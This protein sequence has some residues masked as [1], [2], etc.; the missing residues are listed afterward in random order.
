MLNAIV[1]FGKWVA[2][3]GFKGAK[4]SDAKAFADSI[5]GCLPSGVEVQLFD[6][7]LVASWRHLYFAALNALM[8]FQNRCN[9]SKSLAV[10]TAL[11]ASAQRQI[12]KALP[13]IGLKPA[14]S[15]VAVLVVGD[16]ADA[17]EAG[18]SAVAAQI[19]AERDDAVLE[20]SAAKIKRIREAFD[21]SDAE[22]TAVSSSGGAAEALVALVLE[23]VA[24]LSTRL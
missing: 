2:V 19:Q 10:E 6:A 8:A 5:R 21:V 22:L 3:G 16:D 14:C 12:K 23:R 17:V 11:Y 9:L 4:I 20:L 13:L 15:H 18:F 1:E 7:D 24:L